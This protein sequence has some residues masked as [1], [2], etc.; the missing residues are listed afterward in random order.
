MPCDRAQPRKAERHVSSRWIAR[1][2][3]TYGRPLPGEREQTSTSIWSRGGEPLGGGFA[4]EVVGV[5]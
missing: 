5:R 1:R 3:R 4:A 2:L